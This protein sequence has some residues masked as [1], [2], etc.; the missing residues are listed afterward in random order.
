MS[1][2]TTT[3]LEIEQKLSQDAEGK[4]K[5]VLI[6][7]LLGQAQN[8]KKAMD[9]GLAPDDFSAASKFRDACDVAAVTV[10]K[11]WMRIHKKANKPG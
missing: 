11:V 7:R 9:A 8:T 10:G 2:Q 3:F 4:E 6:E 1:E 5:A